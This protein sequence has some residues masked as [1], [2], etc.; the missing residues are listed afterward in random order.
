MIDLRRESI[1]WIGAAL[2]L[3][4]QA[5]PDA[6]AALEYRRAALWTQPWRVLGAHF[7]HVNGMHAAINAAAWCVL[8]HLFAPVLT[9][10]RQG[11]LLLAA[12]AVIAVGLAALWPSIDWYRGL[13]GV[14]HALFLGGSL[15]WLA[16]ALLRA[17]RRTWSAFVAAALLGGGWLKVALEQPA[18]GVLPYAEWLGAA[19][20]PQA[21]LLGALAGTVVGAAFAV[22]GHRINRRAGA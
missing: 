13:S 3:V 16:D 2:I 4:L 12:A 6:G 1:A 10:F 9:A 5:L 19:V 18:A 7:V 17:P 20:V 14:L 21:H 15:L 11:L 22:T 8:A